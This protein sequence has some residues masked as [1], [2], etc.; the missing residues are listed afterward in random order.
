MLRYVLILAIAA[1]CCFATDFFPADV[2]SDF[3]MKWY[4]SQLSALQEEPMARLASKKE[5]E[6]YRFTWLRTFHKPVVLRVNVDLAGHGILTIKV[7]DGAGGYK[8]GKLIRNESAVMNDNVIRRLRSIIANSEFFEMAPVI[9]DRG[10]DGS[11]WIVEAVSNGRYH[12]VA[13]WTPTDGGVHD[14]GMKL[15]ETAIG[16]DFVPIY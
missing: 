16:G 10:N 2:F 15:I 9:K 1:S 8:P 14:F 5:N 13:R 7:A 4:G 6:V 3:E 12:V 11:E